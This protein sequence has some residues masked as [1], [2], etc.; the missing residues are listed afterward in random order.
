MNRLSDLFRDVPEPQ[1]SA[2]YVS[3]TFDALRNAIDALTLERAFEELAEAYFLLEQRCEELAQEE[4]HR[5]R[6]AYDHHTGRWM[7]FD[8]HVR[9]LQFRVMAHPKNQAALTERRWWLR[10]LPD[11][12]PPVDR[13][14][15]RAREDWIL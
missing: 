13:N 7:P 9:A 3:F 15:W 2:A 11:P 5:E 4:L 14:D 1:L 12:G 10:N 6:L 8:D